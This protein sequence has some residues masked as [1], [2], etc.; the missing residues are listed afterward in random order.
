LVVE[1]EPFI[2]FLLRKQFKIVFFLKK[3]GGGERERERALLGTMVQWITGVWGG[4]RARTPHHHALSCFP[5]HPW[6]SS[7]LHVKDF[8]RTLM[9]GRRMVPLSL[10]ATAKR[11]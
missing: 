8:P 5:T 1:S 9:R 10:F 4:A 7:I 2:L 6:Q 11:H 3:S